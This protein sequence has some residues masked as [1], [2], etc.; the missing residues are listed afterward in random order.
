MRVSALSPA[1]SSLPFFSFYY[2]GCSLL[3]T[4]MQF[5][6]EAKPGTLTAT[7]G[8]ERNF[9]QGF[10]IQYV[11]SGTSPLRG[12][13]PVWLVTNVRQRGGSTA[14]LVKVLA[15]GRINTTGRFFPH[16]RRDPECLR[17]TEDH[18]PDPGLTTALLGIVNHSPKPKI[19]RRNN[20][21]LYSSEL[22][23]PAQFP[24]S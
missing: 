24:V 17:M 22:K 19:A 15:L 6:I 8:R 16:I 2:P 21:S 20:V 11:H 13:A 9:F 1:L 10:L 5:L 18:F 12:R 23:A 14:P 7:R 4:K 3:S